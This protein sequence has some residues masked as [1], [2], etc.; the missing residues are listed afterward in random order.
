MGNEQETLRFD[1]GPHEYWIGGRRIESVTQIL[2][3]ENFIKE[4]EHIDAYY[5]DKGT[6]IHKMTELDDLGLLD[7]SSLH[8]PGALDLTGYLESWRKYKQQYGATY[9]REEVEVRGYDPI[10]MYATTIDRVDCEIKSGG[11]AKWHKYQIAAEWNVAKIMKLRAAPTRNVYLREDGSMP[12]VKEYTIAE[13]RNNLA[14]FL[15]I[16]HVLRARG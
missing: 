12:Q 2:Q 10:Y 14:T 11:P 16:L 3:R 5:L 1:A 6:A 8:V 4:S 15:C 13:L 9:T 7:E